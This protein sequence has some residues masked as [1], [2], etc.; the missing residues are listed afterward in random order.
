MTAVFGFSAHTILGTL[1]ACKA[2]NLY[3]KIYN[4]NIKLIINAE[5]FKL[6]DFLFIQTK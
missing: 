1:E 4:V 5:R 6:Q 3:T 2:L